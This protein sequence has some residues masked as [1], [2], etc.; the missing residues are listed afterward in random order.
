ML[1]HI[2]TLNLVKINK[3]GKDGHN[4]HRRRRWRSINHLLNYTPPG[5]LAE[6]GLQ[7]FLQGQK[8]GCGSY[9]R[10]HDVSEVRSHNR[11]GSSPGSH[12]LKSLEQWDPQYAHSVTQSHKDEM[13]PQLT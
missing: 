3:D 8:G 13:V 10:G 1:P 7:I 4:M 12:Q 5:Q 2:V 11:K 6:A 9:F